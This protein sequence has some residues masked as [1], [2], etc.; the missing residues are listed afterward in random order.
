MDT[1]EWRNYRDTHVDELDQ[2]RHHP[3]RR[4]DNLN[5]P[6]HTELIK[7]LTGEWL[8]VAAKDAADLAK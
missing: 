2:L 1:W 3:R 8:G 6:P 5:P 7:S 4:A